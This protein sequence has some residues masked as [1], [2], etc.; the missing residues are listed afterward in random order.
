MG[1]VTGN[2]HS[3]APLSPAV[4]SAI[5]T[6]LQT[7]QAGWVDPNKQTHLAAKARALRD[8]A[9]DQISS[10]LGIPNLIPYSDVSIAIQIGRAHV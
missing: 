3:E 7:G 10:I 8:S 4:L 5:N 1:S 9:L 2:F 6:A